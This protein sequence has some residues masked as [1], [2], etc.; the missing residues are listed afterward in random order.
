MRHLKNTDPIT[1]LSTDPFAGV[2]MEATDPPPP[3]EGDEDDDDSDDEDEDDDD[4]SDDE[5]EDEEL[6]EKGVKALQRERQAR[7]DAEK[8]LKR[9]KREGEDEQAT[10]LREATEAVETKYHGLI[11]KAAFKAGLAEAG[12][13]K[14]Q[15]KLLKLLDLEEVTVDEDGEVS[16]VDEQVRDLRK[17]FPE[18]FGRGRESGGK[19]DG[20]AK[21][22]PGAGKPKSSAERL[23]ASARG[24]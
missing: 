17:E 20:G 12:L 16:G 3:P 2:R 9:L 10:A 18:L 21:G 4:D 8:E 11:A 23:A 6:G 5:D 19:G 7:K 22:D 15:G 14:G 1:S 13:K 24:E